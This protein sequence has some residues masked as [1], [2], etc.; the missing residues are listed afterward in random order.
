[1]TSGWIFVLRKAAPVALLA[2]LFLSF[3]FLRGV[4]S[5]APALN[6]NLRVTSVTGQGRLHNTAPMYDQGSYLFQIGFGY[7]LADTL[8]FEEEATGAV[9]SDIAR[10]RFEKARIYLEKSLQLDPANGHTWQAYA[11]A[12]AV[13]GDIGDVGVAIRNSWRLAPNDSQLAF[14]RI[15]TIDFIGDVTGD[16]SSFAPIVESEKGVLRFHAPRLLKHLPE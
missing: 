9:S 2:L 5:N 13:I 7:V 3:I 6:Q 15:Y 8:L 16:A 1:M 12:L 10:A 4:A 14:R 11:Q